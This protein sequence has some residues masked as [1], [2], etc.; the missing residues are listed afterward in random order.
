MYSIRFSKAGFQGEQRSVEMTS[1]QDL[2]VPMTFLRGNVIVVAPSAATLKVNGT[3]VGAQ[4]PAE[5]SI[6]PGLYRISAEL[7]SGTRYQVL[8]IKPGARLRLEVRP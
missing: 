6:A 4:T 5:L 7:A 8:M 1:S 2:A 3:R